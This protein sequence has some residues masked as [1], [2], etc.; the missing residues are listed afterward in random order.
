VAGYS[1]RDL[2]TDLIAGAIVSKHEEVIADF[3]AGMQFK[4]LMAKHGMS[5]G[6]IRHILNSR[7]VRQEHRET[8]WDP[9]AKT[10]VQKLW[11]THTAKQIAG[12]LQHNGRQVSV[13]AVKGVVRRI[14]L[15]RDGKPPP[16]WKG[17]DL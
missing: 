16:H 9:E 10:F 1:E 15:K 3:L 11:P 5:R 2:S 13:E 12:E 14:G 6:G 17:N 8:P 4:D 7:G